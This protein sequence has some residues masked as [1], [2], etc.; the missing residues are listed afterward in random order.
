M[1]C[2]IHSVFIFYVYIH[3]ILAE[4]LSLAFFT[5]NF[6]SLFARHFVYI[7]SINY[8]YKYNKKNIF[9]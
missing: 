1:D 9:K 7:T 3:I 6:F 8:I 2:C 5:F 4:H